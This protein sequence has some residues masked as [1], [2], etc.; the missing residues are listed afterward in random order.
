MDNHGFRLLVLITSPKLADKASKLYSELSI[1]VHYRLGGRGTATSEMLDILG[2]GSSQT[3]LLLSFL[4]TDSA[5]A[6]LYRLNTELRFR[7][8]G[9]GLAFILPISGANNI[10]LKLLEES[11]SLALDTPPRKEESSMSELKH[12]LIIAI[13]APGYSEDVMTAAKAVGAR[14]GT[15]LHSRC[16]S[17][18]QKLSLWGLTLQEEKELILIV[19]NTET[20]LPIMQAI[21]EKCGI[22]SEARGLVLSLPIDTVVGL[23]E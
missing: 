13:A 17:D 9:N 8:P 2:I 5:E 16:I 23:S 18:E 3:S 22:H 4:P 21:S 12:V 11:T 1:P 7:I 19:A 20:K 6:L 10:I 15:I 14:G